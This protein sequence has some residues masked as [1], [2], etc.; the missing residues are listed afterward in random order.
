MR[1]PQTWASSFLSALRC[2]RRRAVA[3]LPLLT[4]LRAR[5]VGRARKEPRSQPIQ[6]HC[7]RGFREG[8]SWVIFN[9]SR[10]QVQ[11]PRSQLLGHRGGGSIR[12]VRSRLRTNTVRRTDLKPESASGEPKPRRHS[13]TYI[14]LVWIGFIIF[15]LSA[16]PVTPVKHLLNK[17]RSEP[18]PHCVLRCNSKRR[19]SEQLHA[20]RRREHHGT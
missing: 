14:G 16:S 19:S 8:G 13:G 3:N 1:L 11:P 12:R 15:I 6:C 2:S 7:R 18:L 20:A 10:T 5:L 4:C 9:K 17:L